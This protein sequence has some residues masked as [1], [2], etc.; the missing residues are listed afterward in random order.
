MTMQQILDILKSHDANVAA[1]V[2]MCVGWVMGFAS[3]TAL[4]YKRNI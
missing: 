1:T 2:M 4:F 3:A